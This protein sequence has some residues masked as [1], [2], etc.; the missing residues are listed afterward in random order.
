MCTFVGE[1]QIGYLSLRS[2]RQAWRM[3]LWM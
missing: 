3:S 2:A 1:I